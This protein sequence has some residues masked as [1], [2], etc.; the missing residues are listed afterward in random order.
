LEGYSWSVVNVQLIDLL[1]YA[2][3]IQALLTLI[4]ANFNKPLEV[5]ADDGTS[6]N[7]GYTVRLS[8]AKPCRKPLRKDACVYQRSHGVYNMFLH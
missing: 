6:P 4:Y 8:V 1:V 2:K 7:S 5:T 3:C